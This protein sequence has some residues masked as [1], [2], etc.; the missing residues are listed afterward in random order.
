[1]SKLKKSSGKA[2]TNPVLII[3]GGARGNHPSAQ[4]LPLFRDSIKAKVIEGY[5]MLRKGASAMEVAVHVTKLLEDNPIYNAGRGSKIQAD[6][7][8][9]M[10]ASIMD[11]SLLRFS[12]VMNIEGI[13]NPVDLAMMLN[14]KSTRVM[15]DKGA[16]MKAREWGLPFKSPYTPGRV[17]EWKREKGGKTGT[18][19]AV[20]LD[21]Y[22]K[23]AAATSTGGR[24]MEWP[25]RISDT[26]TVAGNYANAVCGLSATGVGEE[27][28]DFA[29]CAKVATRVEDGMTLKEAMQK[30]FRAAKKR[31]YHFGAIALNAR[32]EYSAMTTTPFMLWAVHDGDRVKVSL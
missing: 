19:G 21:C 22:G 11:G 27:I 32:G 5:E 4:M 16:A 8:I 28:V 6:G 23:I 13:K 30:T 2:R 3:H 18:V 31:D 20:A 24:G 1:M 29:L 15:S 9:R 17:E 14:D 12:G 25:G 26:P 10:S 7:K